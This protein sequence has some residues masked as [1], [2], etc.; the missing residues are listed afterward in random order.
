MVILLSLSALFDSC[1]SEELL[2]FE[3]WDVWEE[4]CF[5]QEAQ[6]VKQDSTRQVAL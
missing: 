6:K 1:V 3:C 4:R 5:T 2:N